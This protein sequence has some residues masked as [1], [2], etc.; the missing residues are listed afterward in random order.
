MNEELSLNLTD[1]KKT[2]RKYGQLSVIWQLG[3]IGQIPWRICYQYK[4][5]IKYE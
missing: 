2:I 4:K 5:N 1:I 3:W